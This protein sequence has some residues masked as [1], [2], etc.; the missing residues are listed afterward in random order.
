MFI[1]CLT[2]KYSF[3]RTNAVLDFQS[4][5]ISYVF[6]MF[7]ICHFPSSNFCSILKGYNYSN[8][9]RKMGMVLFVSR[10]VITE[11]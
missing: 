8:C 7:V 3:Y 10:E 1:I 9:V 2:E 6:H 11:G 4:V 5:H